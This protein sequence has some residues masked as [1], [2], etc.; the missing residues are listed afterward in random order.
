MEFFIV[1]CPGIGE[2]SVDGSVQGEN[3]EKDSC[4]LIVFQCGRGLHDISI[5]CLASRTCL[6]PVKRVEIKDTNPIQPMGVPCICA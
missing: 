5:T 3:K 4:N 1:P 2:V 6:D